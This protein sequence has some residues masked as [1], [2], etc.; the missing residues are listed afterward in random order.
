MQSVMAHLARIAAEA[1][2]EGRYDAMAASMLTVSEANG[3]FT[4]IREGDAAPVRSM[5]CAI[6]ARERSSR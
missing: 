1:F 2:T 3:M 6:V 5:P 4:A